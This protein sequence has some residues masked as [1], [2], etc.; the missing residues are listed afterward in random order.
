MAIRCPNPSNIPAIAANVHN[1]AL[2][3]PTSPPMHNMHTVTTT[4]QSLPE[5]PHVTF[6]TVQPNT[7]RFEYGPLLGLS[8]DNAT[9]AQQRQTVSIVKAG[10][11][12]WGTF[13]RSV[14]HVNARKPARKPCR[15]P[16]QIKT[17]FMACT[18]QPRDRR[19]FRTRLLH[20]LIVGD[21]VP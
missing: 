21:S 12:A 18:H 15:L 20:A 16:Q 5:Y 11:N 3:Y 19:W 6:W 10:R 9:S 13:S 2:S 8:S 1:C 7:L 4:L 14:Q 17:L